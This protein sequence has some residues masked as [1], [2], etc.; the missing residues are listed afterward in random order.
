MESVRK[1]L[2]FMEGRFGG[3]VSLDE[4]SQAAGISRCHFAHVFARATGQ[5]AMRYM[6]GRR[7]SEAA[8]VLANGGHDILSVA[9]DFGYGSHEAFTRAFRDQ[10]GLTP[11]SVRAQ[12]HIDNVNLVEAIKMDDGVITT[13]A[14]PRIEERGL[15]LIAGLGGKY[16][17][18]THQNIPALWQRLQ[19]HLGH[20]PGQVF[21]GGG[22]KGGRTFGVCY[23][24]DDDCSFDYLAGVEVS[25]FSG[26]P[27]EFA[28]LRIPPSGTPYL[29]TA[30][31]F[32]P[33]MTSSRRSGQNGFPSRA[34]WPSMRLTSNIT[35][36]NSTGEQAWA[37]TKSGYRSRLSFAPSGTPG[38]PVFDRKDRSCAYSFHTGYQAGRSAQGE[39]GPRV[40][41]SLMKSHYHLVLRSAEGASRRT[42]QRL[43][44]V[45]R[46]LERPSTRRLRRR[47]RT[48]SSSR[49]AVT[50]NRN[51]L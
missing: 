21:P 50:P 10:F 7:L 46:V 28:R 6:R 43:T 32:Q 4:L 51:L 11:E 1:A 5:S 47:L 27:A 42:L 18:D 17:S 15:L 31:T 26:L 29:R 37:V 16:S 40:R 39:S 34:T 20:V 24:M 9:L 38:L 45:G 30:N 49:Q 35:A 41:C 23:N 25:G 12:R 14:P 48:R 8:R 13:L 19:P 22:G 44:S 2:W 3:E 33:C 36:R